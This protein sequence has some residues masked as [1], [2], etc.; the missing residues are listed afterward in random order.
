MASANDLVPALIGR[1]RARGF[2]RRVDLGVRVR[3][4]FGSRFAGDARRIAR[5]RAPTGVR[6]RRFSA[7]VANDFG[8]W[9]ALC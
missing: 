7:V 9:F 8:E 1:Y 5:K 6:F 4:R 3:P 2:I